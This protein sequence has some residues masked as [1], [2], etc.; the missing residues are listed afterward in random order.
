MF[1]TN[2][3]NHS[4]SLATQEQAGIGKEETD[5]ATPHKSRGRCNFADK[6]LGMPLHVMVI[7][8]VS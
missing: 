8:Q 1:K 7:A 6:I 3:Q 2:N 4:H 5:S